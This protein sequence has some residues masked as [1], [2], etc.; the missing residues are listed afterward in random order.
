[1]MIA[2]LDT[3]RTR[4]AP[5][6]LTALTA[7][8]GALVLL[9]LIWAGFDPR[10]V[11]GAPVWMKPL[12]FA[13]SFVLLFAT[14]ALLEA[15]LSPAVRDGR[16]ARATVTVMGTAFFTEMAYMIYQAA[17]AE[18]SHF[19]MSTPFHAFMYV[20]VMGTGAVLLVLGVGVFGVLAWRDRTARL[21]LALHEGV[22]LGFAL[23]FLLTLGVAGYMSGQSGHHVGLHP[24]GGAVLPLLGWSGVVGDLRPAHFLA[25]HAMQV[26]PLLGLWLDRSGRGG[27]GTVR[28]AA[29]GYAALTLAVF[30]QA[31]LGLPLVRL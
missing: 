14:L 8:A 6:P 2:D 15:R 18:P 27:V 10:Q 12:K 13:L 5:R 16:L 26:L 30:A 25:L 7:A 21:G 17:Q 29:L 28:L 31:L 22:G 23:S 19:N 3:F 24:E 4:P 1:M 9:A 11:G 20:T